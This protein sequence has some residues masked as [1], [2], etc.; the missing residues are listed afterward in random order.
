MIL[1]STVALVFALVGIPG[2]Y[3]KYF[4]GE[5]RHASLEITPT[6]FSSSI[7][8]LTH[9]GNAALYVTTIFTSQGIKRKK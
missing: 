2:I 6:S 5:I 7:W 9:L 3:F 4:G 8:T 1:I